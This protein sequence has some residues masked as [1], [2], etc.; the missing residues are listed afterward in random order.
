[1]LQLANVSQAITGRSNART[2]L[3]LLNAFHDQSSG[4]LK[5]HLVFENVKNGP[6]RDSATL[7]TDFAAQNSSKRKGPHAT[8]H[9]VSVAT[10]RLPV[11]IETFLPL[12][13]RSSVL[14]RRFIFLF[15]FFASAS[16]FVLRQDILLARTLIFTLIS[17]V[18][19]DHF[20]FHKR[21]FYLPRLIKNAL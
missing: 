17:F 9:P 2:L 21:A 4:V 18:P 10:Q 16:Q 7:S 20:F 15:V 19:L 3:I 14:F 5:R 11:A 12:L 8:P 13:C 1:M 6:K